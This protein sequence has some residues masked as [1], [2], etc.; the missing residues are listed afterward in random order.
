MLFRNSAQPVRVG[1][2]NTAPSITCVACAAPSILFL[3]MARRW[4]FTLNNPSI[5]GSSF[6]DTSSIKIGIWQLE[7]GEQ[8]VPHYQGFVIF[9]IGRRLAHCKKLIPRAHWEVAKGTDSENLKYCTK[10][11]GRLSQPVYFP[12]QTVV[13]D[14]CKTKGQSEKKRKLSDILVD[15]CEGIDCSSDDRYI[16]HSKQIDMLAKR[17]KLEDEN[18]VI[19]SRY[20]GVCWLPWQNQVFEE[21]L[22]QNERQVLWVYESKGD[23]GKSFLAKFLRVSCNWAYLEGETSM[24][25]IAHMVSSCVGVVID[26]PRSC[27]D[28]QDHVI[29]S[30]ATLEKLKNGHLF[31]TKYEGLDRV[32]R[33]Y[34]VVIFANYPPDLTKL[35]I[36]RWRCAQI[37]RQRLVFD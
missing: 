7:Q 5:D 4:C 17:R 21:I 13:I 9:L 14:Y 24:H 25:K 23:V 18:D 20:L 30:Y 28:D 15:V 8:C 36:D 1:D 16:L 2:R 37:I 26:I 12:D 33:S 34:P 11:D 10:N 35:S 22:V 27:T 3:F 19:R 29:C 31:T 32:V 6:F